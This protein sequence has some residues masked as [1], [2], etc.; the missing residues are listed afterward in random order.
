MFPQTQINIGNIIDEKT[1]E[2]KLGKSFLFDFSKGDF[3]LKG[4]KL[5][6]TSEIEAIKVWIEKVL[7][8]EKFKF[9]IYEK[10]D[11]KR[12]YGVTIRELLIGNKYPQAFVQ[13]E[14]KREITEALLKHPQ[15][16]TIKE[17]TTDK[18][19]TTLNIYFTVILKDA[20]SFEQEVSFSE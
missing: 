9:K 11:K 2:N 10:Q 6:E 15:I 16:E 7:R 19:Y 4:G 13:S 3:I 12:E 8:T 1:S 17:F 5:I 18:A 20:R 14:L